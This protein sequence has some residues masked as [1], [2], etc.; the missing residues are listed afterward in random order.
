[1]PHGMAGNVATPLA[2]SVSI[3]SPCDNFGN[4]AQSLSTSD[5]LLATVKLQKCA[6]SVCEPCSGVGA[7]YTVV[8]FIQDIGQ[9]AK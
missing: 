7:Y 9:L 2:M 5:L 8:N 6:L 3:N 1:M 4:K